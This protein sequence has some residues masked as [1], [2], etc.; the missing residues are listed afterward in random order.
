MRAMKHPPKS[1]KVV[2]RRWS[3]AK[4][5]KRVR[6]QAKTAQ[7]TSHPPSLA[8]STTRCSPGVGTQGR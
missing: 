8:Q 3:R 7:N 6:L 5:T 4:R 1:R 2:S